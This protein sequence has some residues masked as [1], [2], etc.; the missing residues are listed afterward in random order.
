MSVY[1]AEISVL[2][3]ASSFPFLDRRTGD[4]RRSMP[5][6]YSRASGESDTR[7]V[8]NDTMPAFRAMADTAGMENPER[9]L[10]WLEKLTKAEHRGRHDT[11]SA[12]RDRVAKKT[13]APITQTKRLWDRWETMKDVA[14][15][16]MIPL[17]LAYEDMVQRNE[18]AAHKYRAERRELQKERHAANL[19]RAHQGVG[20]G[21]TRRRE[22]AE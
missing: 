10:F 12:A 19:E 17:M 14:G 22:M 2:G 8:E 3:G 13:G 21:G 16:V 1:P 11:L 5:Q 18:A 7:N 20:E 4:R 6:D 9:T 15:S